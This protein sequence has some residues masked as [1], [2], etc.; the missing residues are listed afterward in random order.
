M[1]ISKRS[2][3]QSLQKQKVVYSFCI[4]VNKVLC[5]VPIR[6]GKKHVDYFPG[7]GLSFFFFFHGCDG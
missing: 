3:Q 2:G 7:D 4:G 1:F 5:Q 6:I